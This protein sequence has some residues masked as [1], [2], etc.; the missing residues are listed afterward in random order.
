M[1]KLLISILIVC[2]CL[3]SCFAL[4]SCGCEK[5]PAN[6]TP[7][8]ATQPDVVDSNGFGYIIV[9][10]KTLT[11]TQYT[12][13]SLEVQVPS[14][15]DGK[16]VTALGNGA[17][18]GTEVTSVT[19]PDTITSIGDRTFSNC[20]NLAS[21]SLPEGLTKIDNNAFEYSFSLKSITLP[22]TLESLGRYAF[23]GSGIESIEIPEKVTL[24]DHFAFFQ[25]SNLKSV[26]IPESVEEFGDGVF[27]GDDNLTITGAEGSAA[28][29][30]AEENN[31]EFIAE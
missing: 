25:C 12:G 24:L 20:P 13:T 9:D 17:F 23:S 5:N 15:Y 31:I 16:T 1:K 30:Y 26:K 18:R 6:S 29:K 3:S 27:Q 22:S 7:T 4:A 28:E 21:I 11:I 14:E 19:V 8:R 10:S 2:L